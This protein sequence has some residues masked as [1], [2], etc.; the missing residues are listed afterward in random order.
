MVLTI[1]FGCFSPPQ[2]L[3]RSCAAVRCIAASLALASV[4][5][6]GPAIAQQGRRSG[7]TSCPIFPVTAGIRTD[8][9]EPVN[10]EITPAIRLRIL[11]TVCPSTAIVNGQ[12][13]G[14]FPTPTG[15]GG[16]KVLSF[17][18]AVR[19][20]QGDK[21]R[22]EWTCPSPGTES[23]VLIRV[24]IGTYQKNVVTSCDF[25]VIEW[26]TAELRKMGIRQAEVR[27]TVEVITSSSE[28]RIPVHVLARISIPAGLLRPVFSRCGETDSQRAC[29]VVESDFAEA[30][31]WELSVGSVLFRGA[32][33]MG[34]RQIPVLRP[35]DC[36]PMPVCV[37][38]NGE[39]PTCIDQIRF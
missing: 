39:K 14:S 20:Q 25:D 6:T 16:T 8:C 33:L 13:E 30:R 27:A 34:R 31:R 37:G 10:Q 35:R 29:L 28:C 23:R 2:R 17:H 12:C 24:R 36:Q 26:S 32:G 3:N 9:M 19:D 7:E 1:G 5:T 11:A 22:V 38:F 4:I 15:D 21:F 18:S